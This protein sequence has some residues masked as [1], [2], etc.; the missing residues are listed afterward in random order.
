MKLLGSAWLKS[1]GVTDSPHFI[2]EL[3]SKKTPSADI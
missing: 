3:V 1:G 2:E